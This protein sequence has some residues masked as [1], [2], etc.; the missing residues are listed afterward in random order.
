M[1]CVGSVV[2]A[3]TAGAVIAESASPFAAAT[4]SNTDAASVTMP[5]LT[6]EPEGDEAKDFDKYY[7][8]HRAE[9]DFATAYADISECDGYASGL[10]SGM[11]YTQVPYPYAGTLGGAIGGALGNAIADAIFGSGERRRVRRMN[12]R[13]CM[14]FKGY[15]RYGLPKAFWEK[16][17]FEEGMGSVEPKRRVAMLRQQAL[18]AATAL[19]VGKA[20]GQ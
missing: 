18:V 13:A 20:L 1:A 19:P 17:N 3:Q 12:M 9:T 8:F 4:I 14:H 7:Y 6:F 5:A 15:D 10:S 11:G 2:Q 16:F